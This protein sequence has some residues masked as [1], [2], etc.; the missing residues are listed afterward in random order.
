MNEIRGNV[1]VFGSLLN[2]NTIIHPYFISEMIFTTNF[3]EETP[4]I[5]EA[6]DK[7]EPNPKLSKFGG[8]SSVHNRPRNFSQPG[9]APSFLGKENAFKNSF[10]Q[11][12]EER[13]V[14]L[15]F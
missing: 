13:V 15:P 1:L 10:R 7:R 2:N 6:F 14:V 4:L 9:E 3:L 8:N 12:K 11:E 5:G